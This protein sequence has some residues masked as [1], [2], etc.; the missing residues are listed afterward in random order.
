MTSAFCS[1]SCF[2]AS[3]KL[4]GRGCRVERVAAPAEVPDREL[5]VR[6]TRHQLRLEVIEITIRSASVLPIST[7]RSFAF[8]SNGSIWA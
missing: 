5:E 1:V 3:R 7:M 2:A 6:M 4:S 8:S